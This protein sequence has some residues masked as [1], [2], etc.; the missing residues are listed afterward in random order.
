[1]EIVKEAQRLQGMAAAITGIDEHG[2]PEF[3]VVGLPGESNL[4]RLVF[5][6]LLTMERVKPVDKVEGVTLYRPL[7]GVGEDARLHGPALAML[8]EALVVGT[9]SAV[10]D[11]IG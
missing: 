3:V 8:P 9:P 1:P 5:R 10:K 4:P 2:Q 7:H 11:V 6:A